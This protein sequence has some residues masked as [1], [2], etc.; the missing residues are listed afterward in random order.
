MQNFDVITRKAVLI[1]S[2]GH[3]NNFLRG[4]GSD[5]R[6]MSKFLQSNKGGAW[7]KEDILILDNPN[8]AQVSLVLRSVTAD[9][10]FVYFSGH[11]YT[12][13]RRGLRMLALR[14]YNIQ[15]LHLLNSSPR[16]LIIVDACR[17]YAAPGLSGVPAFE[18]H[19]DH[20]E[21]SPAHELFNE[22][23]ACSPEGKLIVHA[24]QPGKVSIDSPSGGHFTQ[25][26]LRV[27]TR[28]KTKEDYLPCLIDSVLT[29]VPGVL[30][31]NRNF[32]IPSIVYEEGNLTVPFALGSTQP[33]LK[34]KQKTGSGELVGTLAITLLLTGLVVAAVSSN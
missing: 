21:G 31:K 6:N 26:L 24:T 2:P 30:R 23:I 33:S 18:D 17:S 34:G 12:D 22:Y 16:Q 32:Q 28:M 11:G 5:I 29:H 7:R 8:L 10:L 15:D 14:D 9:Y 13:W 19:V 25:A 4:V 1:G 20:F 27:A 3:Q